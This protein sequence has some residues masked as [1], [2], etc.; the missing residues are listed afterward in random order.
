MAV[1][2]GRRARHRRRRR[3]RLWRLLLLGRRGRLRLARGRG[4][5]TATAVRVGDRPRDPG[6]VVPVAGR[7]R[8]HRLHHRVHG[9]VRSGHH[10]R[11]RR[12][13]SENDGMAFLDS[14]GRP[15]VRIVRIKRAGKSTGYE[16]PALT[17]DYSKRRPRTSVRIS[18]SSPLPH[19]CPKVPNLVRNATDTC[20]RAPTT[21]RRKNHRLRAPAKFA[22]YRHIV[23]FFIITHG[24]GVRRRVCTNAPIGLCAR[25]SKNSRTGYEVVT[26]VVTRLR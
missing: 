10:H 25:C 22:G 18:R 16:T 21:M 4:M 19:P 26:A 24:V 6:S 8:L 17:T 3:R 15:R 9:Q 1:R 5:A 13:T 7:R 2:R 12:E 14:T 20:A 11:R 23:F